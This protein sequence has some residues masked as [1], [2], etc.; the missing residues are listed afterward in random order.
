M[1]IYPPER[2]RRF[3]ISSAIQRLEDSQEFFLF[4]G[5][6]KRWKKQT[7]QLSDNQVIYGFNQYEICLGRRVHCEIDNSGDKYEVQRY[8]PQYKK[9]VISRFSRIVGDDAS[10]ASFGKFGAHLLY[11]TL[12]QTTPISFERLQITFKPWI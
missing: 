3:E 8:I 10:H 1:I 7:I 11:D 9:E 2:F 12:L 5:P 6:F 4:F